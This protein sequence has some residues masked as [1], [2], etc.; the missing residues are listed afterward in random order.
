MTMPFF[1]LAGVSYSYESGRRALDSID[2]TVSAGVVTGIIGPN[3]SGKSTLLQVMSGWL[4]PESGD[5]TV[6]GSRVSSLSRAQVAQHIAFVPQ[7]EDGCFSFSVRDTVL[8]GRYA[9]NEGY[10]SFETDDDDRLAE[11]ALDAVE[12]Q[13]FASRSAERLSAGE[14]QRML[15]ARALV[16]QTP[17][18]LLDEPTATLDLHHQRRVMR[19]M[20]TLAKVELK[21]IVI[22]LHD[23]NLAAMYCDELVLMERGRIAARGPVRDVLA[24][25]TLERVYQ[26]P[27]RISS[28]TPDEISVMIEP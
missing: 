18:L 24:K 22:V 9:A 7:R 25:E 2:L 8:F 23:L 14:R 5:V 17:A 10:H 21:A 26:T 28:S 19:M 3:G 20:T 16:Q 4:E 27:L 11:E 13:E 1:Q 15:I 12:L 6:N